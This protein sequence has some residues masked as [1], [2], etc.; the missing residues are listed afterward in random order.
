MGVEDFNTAPIQFT[1]T[2]ELAP[3]TV[4]FQAAPIL[5]TQTAEM[6]PGI[7]WLQATS[8][9][10]THSVEMSQGHVNLQVLNSLPDI[11]CL[12]PESIIQDNGQSGGID[13]RSGLNTTQSVKRRAGRRVGSTKKQRQAAQPKVIMIPSQEEH[14]L[15]PPL[16]QNTLPE[17]ELIDE[18]PPDPP[19]EQ[20]PEP[21]L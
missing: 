19:I 12:Q 8:I 15:I 4:W 11:Q 10:S 20:L 2:T 1:H 16:A 6:G 7:V 3:G 14:E 13:L 5:N 9:S 17:A 18:T 21:W